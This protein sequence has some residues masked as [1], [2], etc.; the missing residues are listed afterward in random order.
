[1]ME[2]V[3]KFATLILLYVVTLI[4]YRWVK[5][6]MHI[7]KLTCPYVETERDYHLIHYHWREDSTTTINIK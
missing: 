6:I 1:M 2:R 5:L 3:D 7:N 4:Q